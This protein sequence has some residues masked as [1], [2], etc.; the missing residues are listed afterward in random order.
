MTTEESGG[1][2]GPVLVLLIIGSSTLYGL[3]YL[4]AV[5]RRANTDYKKTKTSLPGLRKDFWKAWWA[6]V[7]IA[8][9]VAIAGLV[10]IAWAI[11][12]IRGDAR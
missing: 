3:G 10:L 6:M 12:D 1:Y 11:Q 8:F 4:T 5:M 2:A 7:K 9:W